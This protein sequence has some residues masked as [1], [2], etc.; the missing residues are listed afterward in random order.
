MKN[1]TLR[2]YNAILKYYKVKNFRSL[3]RHQKKAKAEELLNSKLCKCINSVTA[4]LYKGRRMRTRKMRSNPAPIRICN[5]SVI[6]N[7]GYRMRKFT[8]KN[9]RRSFKIVKS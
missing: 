1:L 8:C 6:K 4:K 2:D 7:K 5:R 9:R 3:T